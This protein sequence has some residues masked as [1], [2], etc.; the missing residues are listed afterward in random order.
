[1]E[2]DRYWSRQ[3][4]IEY[5][6]IQ[7]TPENMAEVAE[8]LHLEYLE[9]FLDDD[10]DGPA[11]FRPGYNTSLR[12]G[13]FVVQVVNAEHQAYGLTTSEMYSLFYKV[14]LHPYVP[15][16]VYSTNAAYPSYCQI[17]GS[18]SITAPYHRAA[19]PG[20][21]IRHPN[22]YSITIDFPH[23]SINSLM[24]EDKR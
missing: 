3:H 19:V 4:D 7:L 23:I 1:M 24:K 20:E 22:G 10:G 12:V 9:S 8:Y 6:G 2:L 5:E 21:V 16:V 13:D 11:L 17:C 14:E 18:Q 15:E